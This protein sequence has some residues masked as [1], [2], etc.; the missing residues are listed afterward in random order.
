VPENVTIKDASTGKEIPRD[1]VFDYWAIDQKNLSETVDPQNGTVTYG[2]HDG[3]FR[4]FIEVP[5]AKFLRTN[6]EYERGEMPEGQRVGTLAESAFNVPKIQFDTGISVPYAVAGDNV[7]LVQNATY[8]LVGDRINYHG[9]ILAER[10]VTITEN[11]TKTPV[12]PTEDDLV[13]ATIVTAP[14]T[15]PS[16]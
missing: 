6:R 4:A 9:K 1:K 16:K 3:K 7:V 15:Q 11:E 10:M 5:G 8:E 13:K 12:K 2:R 14:T